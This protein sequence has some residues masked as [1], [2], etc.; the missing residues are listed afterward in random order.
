MDNARDLV[1][2]ALE[3]SVVGS[4]SRIGPAVRRRLD[5]WSAPPPAVLAGRTV[6]VTGPTSGLGLAAT[7]ALAG[8]GARVVLVGRDRGAAAGPR[9]G[10]GRHP[11][12]RP[13][14]DRG[15]RHGLARVGA[16][17]GRAHPRDR[18][19]TR[20]RDRQRR[21]DVPGPSQR[22]RRDRGDVRA[23]R[24]RP[25][26]AGRRPAAA[27]KADRWVARRGRDL[28]RDVCTRAGPRRPRVA[29]HA[30]LGRPRLRSGEAAQVAL[31]REWSR[32]LAPR[33]IT[34]AAMHPGWADTP[35]LAESLPVF[36]RLMRPLLRS[37]GDAVDTIVWLATHP[38]QRSTTGRLFLDRR[39][40][41][42][43]RFPATRLSAS[44]RRRLWDLVVALADLP[45]PAPE[46]LTPVVPA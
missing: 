1:D 12:R 17:G 36:Y 16:R 38:N 28:G 10:S 29:C 9:R 22:P 31:M 2:A 8:L 26:R 21:C 40:R 27:P 34:F 14:P 41:P 5:G 33:G 24:R 25:V 42:F 18:D 20:R 35:G 30:L 3:I 7:K 44:Q 23:A 37:P 15:R 39:P 6:V 4:F 19:S 13:V 43:D 11:C 32:R 46:E 45:D